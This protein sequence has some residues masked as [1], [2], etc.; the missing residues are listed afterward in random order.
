MVNPN[1]PAVFLAAW[2]VVTDLGSA[3]APLAISLPTG[4]ANLAWAAAAV[5]LM[6]FAGAFSSAGTGR[7][8]CARPPPVGPPATQPLP[9]PDEPAP[10]NARRRTRCVSRRPPVFWSARGFWYPEQ[11]RRPGGAKREGFAEGIQALT[12]SWRCQGDRPVLGMCATRSTSI[13][14]AEAGVI[15]SLIYLRSRSEYRATYQRWATRCII[16]SASIQ[17]LEDRRRHGPWVF[18]WQKVTG[19]S[20]DSACDRAS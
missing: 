11:L 4:V 10:K 8:S 17:Q 9:R 1:G 16:A 12:A 19:T 5:G 3:G 7:R 18:A 2:R 20:D 6:G 14:R 13:L 15:A